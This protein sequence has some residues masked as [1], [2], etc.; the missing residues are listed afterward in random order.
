[1]FVPSPRFLVF[2]LS[3]CTVG[4]L[5]LLMVSRYGSFRPCEVLHQEILRE[6]A[7]TGQSRAATELRWKNA[8]PNLDAI[9]CMGALI[10][11]DPMRI[12]G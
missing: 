5:L 12:L 2:F 3:A 7:T 9:A 11:R 4:L 1:M 10:S 8:E 6:A